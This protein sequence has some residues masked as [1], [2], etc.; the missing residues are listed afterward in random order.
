MVLWFYGGLLGL[1]WKPIMQ[2]L[3]NTPAVPVKNRLVPLFGTNLRRP[4]SQAFLGKMTLDVD[5]SL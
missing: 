2:R 5:V 3:H 1:V 4:I